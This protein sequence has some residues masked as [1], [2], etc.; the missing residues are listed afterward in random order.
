MDYINASAGAFSVPS[1]IKSYGYRTT[2]V[3]PATDKPYITPQG[4]AAVPNP[5]QEHSMNYSHFLGSDLRKHELEEL[6]QEVYRRVSSNTKNPYKEMT[7]SQIHS[8]VESVI[9]KYHEI[10]KSKGIY[11]PGVNSVE[12]IKEIRNSLGLKQGTLVAYILNATLD[13]TSQGKLEPYVLNPISYN[14]PE[15]FI[16]KASGVA[17]KFVDTG[18]KV[19]GVAGGAIDKTLNKV[20]IAGGIAVAGLFVYSRV[21]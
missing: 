11:K 15:S 14:P 6:S 18:A 17:K 8:L 2:V 9:F 16:Q 3:D 21:K 13:L 10:V 19:V 20:L 1:D 5:F 7:L 12:I 4:Y